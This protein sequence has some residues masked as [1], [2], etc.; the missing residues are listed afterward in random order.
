MI[1]L[2]FVS[3]GMLILGVFFFLSGII[4]LW[5]FPDP[6]CRLHAITKA[7]NLGLGFIVLAVALQVGWSMLLL[8]LLAI[9]I[10]VL[11][12]S[13]LNGYL[14]AQHA[15]HNSDGERRSEK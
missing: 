3:G 14:I 10:L 2:D 5:R 4:A 7:D 6:L 8:K 9:Y 15:H 12:G 13:A 1:V 11:Y